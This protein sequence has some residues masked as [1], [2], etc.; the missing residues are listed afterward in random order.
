M[1]NLKRWLA[2]SAVAAPLAL[3]GGCSKEQTG[4]VAQYPP[5]PPPAQKMSPSEVSQAVAQ[6]P[7][8]DRGFI[9]QAA[10]AN[11]TAIR[12]GQLAM[13]RGTS[14][15][16]RNL[17]RE[18]VDNNTSLNDRM[19]EAARREGVILPIAQPTPAQ[20]STLMQLSSLYGAE[21]D[22]AFLDS[23]TNLQNESIANF[24]NEAVHGKDPALADLA[25]SALPVLNE[26]TRTV[27]RQMG[28]M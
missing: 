1:P 2:I 4:T 16:V 7:E 11:I 15:D 3:V 19:R 27:Q 5:A 13:A 6:L 8:P 28:R 20:Q 22:R 26:R 10:G 21:F 25:N 9:Q 18:M 23:V 14:E 12:L 17:G 24:Q